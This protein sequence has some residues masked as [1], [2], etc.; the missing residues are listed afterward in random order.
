MHRWCAGVQQKREKGGCE[1]SKLGPEA[2][3]IDTGKVVRVMK[4]EITNN[5]QCNL[6][7]YY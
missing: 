7:M 5:V 4:Q 1:V 6:I 2:V 3:A